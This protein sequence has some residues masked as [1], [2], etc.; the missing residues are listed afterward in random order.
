M[1]GGCCHCC[2]VLLVAGGLS[3]YALFSYGAGMPGARRGVPL[4]DRPSS[5]SALAV[6]SGYSGALSSAGGSA[7]S[8]A[9]SSPY[10]SLAGFSAFWIAGVEVCVDF[11][12]E[13]LRGFF[14]FNGLTVF[15]CCIVFCWKRFRWRRRKRLGK[16]DLGF[17]PTY[18]SAG[19]ALRILQVQIMAQ[20]QVQHVLEEK[21]DDEAEEDADGEPADPEKHLHRQLRRIRRGETVERLTALRRESGAGVAGKDAFYA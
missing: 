4:R 5:C 13:F 7:G 9:A 17:F 6:V 14:I 1:A 20:P 19:N 18:T 12:T 8:L 2:S 16:R 10:L 3:A 21:L 11:A 15:L